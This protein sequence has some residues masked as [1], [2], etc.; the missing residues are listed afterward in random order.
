ME[1]YY[2]R[3]EQ[4][5][6]GVIGIKVSLIIGKDV[7]G[8]IDRPAGSPHPRHPDMIY[9]INYGFVEGIM[10]PDGDEQDVYVLGTDEPLRTFEGKVI[11][12]FHRLND[13][14]I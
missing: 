7:K 2:S 10:A 4:E 1:V 12:V 5:Q 8:I 14:A 6:Y 3:E 13:V 9:P 11:A